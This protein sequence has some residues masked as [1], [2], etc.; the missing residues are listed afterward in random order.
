MSK[1]DLELDDDFIDDDAE[2]ISDE[3][4]GTASKSSLLKRRD[5]D[6]LLHERRLHKALAEYDYDFD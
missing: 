2:E 6:N 3:E 1:E 4:V 5:I